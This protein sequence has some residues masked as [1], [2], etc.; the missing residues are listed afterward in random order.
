MVAVR[1][2]SVRQS[3]GPA[4]RPDLS[5]AEGNRRLIGIVTVD[6]NGVGS[7]RDAPARDATYEAIVF[8]DAMHARSVSNLEHVTVLAS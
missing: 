2:V 3:P 5:G 6:D 7:L 4:R 8:R 1:C